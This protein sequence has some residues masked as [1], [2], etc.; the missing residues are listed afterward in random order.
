M[1][2]PMEVFWQ[3]GQLHF[4]ASPFQGSSPPPP[5][6]LQHALSA[7]PAPAAPVP[8]AAVP[9]RS[10][11]GPG[12]ADTGAEPPETLPRAGSAPAPRAP[13]RLSPCTASRAR[14]RLKRGRDTP[15]QQRLQLSIACA[16]LQSNPKQISAS[17]QLRAAV[18]HHPLSCRTSQPPLP[19]RFRLS[20]GC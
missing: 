5:P 14:R 12:T 17:W 11:A 16:L 4:P 6:S 10:C 7:C 3:E 18:E 1:E 20:L 9:A 8:G 2:L 13:P 19:A 15:M